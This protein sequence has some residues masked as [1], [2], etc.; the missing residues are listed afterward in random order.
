MLTIQ[1]VE[2]QSSLHCGPHALHVHC[3]NRKQE[4]WVDR[5]GR[6]ECESLTLNALR[7]ATRTATRMNMTRSFN[8]LRGCTQCA[9]AT[10]MQDRYVLCLYLYQL[11]VW[12]NF[13][14]CSDCR[15]SRAVCA[16]GKIATHG[17][18]ILM[19]CEGQQNVEPQPFL[20]MG[21]IDSLSDRDKGPRSQT[22]QITQ[23]LLGVLTSKQ[24]QSAMSGRFKQIIDGFQP[25][26]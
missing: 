26:R 13:T 7:I 9:C 12:R 1:N 25:L 22:S 20:G 19:L 14:G 18:L 8:G 6:A 24:I 2:K 10:C 11:A 4:L 5:D 23:L 15:A 17:L 16:T 21:C 3:D